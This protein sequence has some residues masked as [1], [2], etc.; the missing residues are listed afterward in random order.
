MNEPER[1]VTDQGPISPFGYTGNTI[2]LYSYTCGVT[3][4]LKQKFAFQV[5]FSSLVYQVNARIEIIIPDTLVGVDISQ[6][7][8]LVTANKEINLTGKRVNPLD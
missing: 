2:I 1:V 3:I 8:I 6:P 4:R 7:V 5:P